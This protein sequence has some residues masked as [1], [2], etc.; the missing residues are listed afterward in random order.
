MRRLC[1]LVASVVIAVPAL[2]QTDPALMSKPGYWKPVTQ[3]LPAGDPA[4]GPE[5]EPFAANLSAVLAVLRRTPLLAQPRGFVAA[6]SLDRELGPPRRPFTGSVRVGLLFFAKDDQGTVA[7]QDGGPDVV[8]EINDASCVWSGHEV[9]FVDSTGPIYYDVPQDSSPVRGIPGYGTDSSC[10]VI[11]RHGLTVFAPVS[12]GRFLRDARDTLLARV[13]GVSMAALDSADP[14]FLYK[15]WLGEGAQRKHQRDSLVASLGALGT[16]V[17]KQV[18]ASY[19]TAQ[20]GMGAMLREQAAAADSGG[21]FAGMRRAQQAALDT[22][23]AV[24]MHYDAELKRMSSAD[25]RAPAWVK[26]TDAGVLDLVP[27]GTED[28]RQLVAPNAA[29]LNP[30]VPRS[31]LQLLAITAVAPGGDEGTTALFARIRQTLDY[32]ALAALLK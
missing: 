23:R 12:R 32:G 5:L 9:A 4:D 28:A 21:G 10:L 1:L 8:V 6:P 2:A 25:A 19:D 29:L 31:A 15:K 27:A 14:R 26:S 24:A 3:N 13:R 16:D 7:P 20:A 18:L 17:R 30:T 22:V 11:A